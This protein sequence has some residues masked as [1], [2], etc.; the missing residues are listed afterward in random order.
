[1][2]RT[3]ISKFM[4]RIFMLVAL[5]A[6]L[7]IMSSGLVANSANAAICCT[8][9][10]TNFDNCLLGCNDNQACIS[11]CNATFAHCEL[12]CNSLC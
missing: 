11:A 5:T 12:F 9:C 7:M 6:G 8:A 1:M 10:G 4:R 2:T 3:E